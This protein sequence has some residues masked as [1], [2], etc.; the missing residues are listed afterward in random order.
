MPKASN[1]WTVLPHQPMEKLA[2]NLWRVTGKLANMPLERAM[3]IARM[4]DGRLFIHNAMALDPDA[5]KEL[6]A[7]GAPAF[8]VVPNGYHRLDCARFA[9][10]YPDAR[11]I[12]PAGSR[13][14][15]EQV[16]AVNATYDEIAG[17]D[18][19]QIEYVDGVKEME[20]VMRVRSDD[21]MTLVFNDLVFNVE[22]QSGF[23]GLVLRA[24]G[25]SGGP[26]VTRLARMFLIKDKAA[27]RADLVRLADTPDLVRIVPG[28]GDVITRD[29]AAILRRI[30]QG[31]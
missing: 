29:P 16:V 10:R 8:V 14:K 24:M 30:A 31:L 26:K 7:L 18:T 3:T 4:Q 15:I 25:S 27:V 2:S 6:E 19:V 5:M 21:G 23:Q 12:C 28:H 9:H 17:D 1:T 11:I 13:E 22:H 20:G